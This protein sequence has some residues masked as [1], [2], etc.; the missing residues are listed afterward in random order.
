MH[1]LKPYPG[2]ER[3]ATP[4]ASS[5]RPP[6]RVMTRLEHWHH[7]LTGLEREAAETKHAEI[8]LLLGMTIL[9]VEDAIVAAGGV[10]A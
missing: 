5:A 6:A 10:A 9:A 2:A 3:A 4:T 8:E 7:I 1:E